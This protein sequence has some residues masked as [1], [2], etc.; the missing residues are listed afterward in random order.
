MTITSEYL[1]FIYMLLFL[2]FCKFIKLSD[3]ITLMMAENDVKV[4]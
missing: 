4:E 1:E 2:Q 3:E